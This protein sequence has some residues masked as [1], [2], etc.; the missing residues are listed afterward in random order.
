MLRVDM[1]SLSKSSINKYAIG[2]ENYSYTNTRAIFFML[3]KARLH[4]EI[5]DMQITLKIKESNKEESK[6]KEWVQDL[7]N[8]LY[9]LYYGG[10]S[11]ATEQ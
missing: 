6:K 2:E 1:S 8:D 3:K 5:S 7:Y 9:K 10:D 11:G 4:T